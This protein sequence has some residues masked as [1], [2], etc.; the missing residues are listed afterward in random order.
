MTDVREWL[1]VSSQ[2]VASRSYYMIILPIASWLS[3]NEI[4]FRT[5]FSVTN[6]PPDLK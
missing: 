4:T 6:C 1:T 3:T 5:W 2:Q